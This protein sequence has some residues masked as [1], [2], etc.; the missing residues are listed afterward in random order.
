[1]RLSDL[2]NI[3]G[4]VRPL[5][6]I[7]MYRSNGKMSTKSLELRLTDILLAG[8]LIQ[9]EDPSYPAMMSDLFRPKRGGFFMS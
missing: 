6:L 1:M 2:D 5:F 9:G 3:I 7:F 8:P 4:Y